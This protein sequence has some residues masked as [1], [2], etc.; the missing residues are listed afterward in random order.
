MKSFTTRDL[1]KKA[2]SNAVEIPITAGLRSFLAT[3]RTQFNRII[4]RPRCRTSSSFSS[5]TD[6]ISFRIIETYDSVG[7]S[8]G[9]VRTAMTTGSKLTNSSHVG[10][11]SRKLRALGIRSRT[12]LGIPFGPI[13]I[14]KCSLLYVH[15]RLVWID[16]TELFR[17]LPISLT[18]PTFCHHV[19]PSGPGRPST[20]PVPV[21]RRIP[22]RVPVAVSR[23]I[24]F[25]V[26]RCKTPFG[27]LSPPG[28]D[29]F[30]RPLF[31]LPV[32]RPSPVSRRYKLT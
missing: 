13:S 22:A 21:R 12:F 24:L 11:P 8:E 32:R 17:F 27:N 14:C 25:S 5:S 18:C 23:N 19:S 16:S 10:E 20:R 9:R 2:L 15:D 1:I 30:F 31:V 7:S 29:T 6:G 3:R 26:I 28:V 4:F